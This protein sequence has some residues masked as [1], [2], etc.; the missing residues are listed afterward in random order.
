MTVPGG[1]ERVNY[2]TKK[3]T[4]EEQEVF[5]WE[6][7]FY[8]EGKG[9]KPGWAAVKYKNKFGVWPE[10]Q[11]NGAMLV[12]AISRGTVLFIKKENRLWAKSQ[13]PRLPLKTRSYR[14]A[15]DGVW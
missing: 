8:G 9:Y 10:W 2:K 13:P 14:D 15:K 4:E 12:E 11:H 6:L 1:L 3:W 7:R 5:Y